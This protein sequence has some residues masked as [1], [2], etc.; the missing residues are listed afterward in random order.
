VIAVKNSL[1][2]AAAV[3]SVTPLHPAECARA[4]I[5]AIERA[6]AFSPHL[7]ALPLYALCG[8]SSGALARSGAVL[9][10]AAE[11]LR[12][13][14]AATCA[15]DAFI[16]IGAPVSGDEALVLLRGGQMIGALRNGAWLPL[17]DDNDILLPG[18]R[19]LIG[20]AVIC[21]EACDPLVLPAFCENAA[22]SD[23]LLCCSAV[24][25]V[26]GGTASRLRAARTLTDALGIGV[27]LCNGNEGE[28]TAPHLY[29]GFCAAYECGEALEE[30][31]SPKA[32]PLTVADFDLD[33]IGA[34]RYFP[35]ERPLSPAILPQ[36]EGGPCRP[37]RKNPF[38]PADADGQD[39]YLA[40]LF[41]LQ[42]ASLAGRM[43]ATG[44][45]RAVVGVSGGLDSTLALLVS[46][47]ALDSLGHPRDQL[48]AVTMPGFGTSDRTYYNALTLMEILG[49]DR[50]EVSIK[51][52]VIQH[53]EDIG[54]DPSKKDVTFEN[55]QARERAQILLDIGNQM[56]GLVVGTGDLSEAALGWSTFGGDHIASFNVNACIPKTIVRLI[57][58]HLA[59]SRAFADAS[60]CLMDVLDTPVS[61][62]LLPPDESGEQRQHT[63]E[64]LGPYELHDFFLYH[65]TV[66]RFAPSKIYAYACVA[67]ADSYEPAE[68]RWT[69]EV[70]L[71]RFVA[72]QFKRSC[73]PDC[74][75]IGPVSLSPTGF[76]FPSDASA[77]TLLDELVGTAD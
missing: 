24:P 13:V 1:R 65:F 31:P 60:D 41:E 5:D 53:L 43:R 7:I 62:E 58:R 39:D 76:L 30:S 35:A 74:A 47:A 63:E 19:F 16:L 52:S 2:I 33:V 14:A 72:G 71:K 25:A 37:I 23:I 4:A 10:A 42:A 8:A 36:T 9:S 55:A 70:F 15:L 38:L 40:E 45:E 57:V 56:G 29:R 20:G 66:H 51:A 44:I 6:D 22:K 32:A 26:A 59:V 34:R 77:E 18:G 48:V 68:I 11:A 3:P 54:H 64:I 27:M 69:L 75:A 28:S 67:F 17:G 49:A 61:P 46:A 73:A 12:A 21:A 50:R